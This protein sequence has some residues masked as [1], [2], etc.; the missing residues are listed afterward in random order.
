VRRRFLDHAGTGIYNKSY[1]S[2]IAKG[3]GFSMYS[4]VDAPTDNI[5]PLKSMDHRR[6]SNAPNDLPAK[7]KAEFFLRPDV[8]HLEMLAAQAT[9][10]IDRKPAEHPARFKEQQKLYGEKRRLLRLARKSFREN[11]FST[12]YDE[13][14]LRQVQPLEDEDKIIPAKPQQIGIFQLTRRFMPARDRI[15]N[16]ILAEPDQSQAALQ[17]IYSLCIDDNWVA[18]RPN[19]HPVGGMCPRDG[20]FTAI[21]E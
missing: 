3:Y 6:N 4:G 19:E 8:Q 1:E 17:D 7:E 12:S 20:C 13:E 18:Y 5:E 9:R 14:A 15:A 16:A 11:W 2:K 21:I 10:D